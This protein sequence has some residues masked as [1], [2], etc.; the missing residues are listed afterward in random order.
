MPCLPVMLGVGLSLSS[1][2][3]VGF[4]RWRKRAKTNSPSFTF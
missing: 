2:V 3:F 4:H 1:F